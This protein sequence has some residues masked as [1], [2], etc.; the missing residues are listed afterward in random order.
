MPNISSAPK[1]EGTQ[2]TFATASNGPE[3]FRIRSGFP[4]IDSDTVTLAFDLSYSSAVSRQNESCEL[5]LIS[6]TCAP[7]RPII[8]LASPVTIKLLIWIF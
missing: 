8:T 4:G 2:L 7:A 5:T 6:L 1:N 3:T